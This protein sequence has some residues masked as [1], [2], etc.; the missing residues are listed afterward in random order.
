MSHV[1]VDSIPHISLVKLDLLLAGNN[2]GADILSIYRNDSVTK[3]TVPTA[4]TNLV[5]NVIGTSV[6]FSWSAASD[7]QT[8]AAGLGYNL[9]VGTTPDG[10]QI[11]SPQSDTNGY[12]RL[13]AL[14]NA[15]AH[16]A[17]RLDSLQPGT[18][19]FWSVQA[20]DSAFAGSPFA[21]AGSSIALAD[22]VKSTHS[23]RRPFAAIAPG[24][25]R[26]IVRWRAE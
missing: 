23:L 7:V 10:S 15:G 21:L 12:R 18:N 20:V 16:L 2:G 9:R 13:T 3:N 19:Y 6:E 11:V 14:G 5:V 1:R 4:P 8:P 24:C 17:A 26:A 22:L 25:P